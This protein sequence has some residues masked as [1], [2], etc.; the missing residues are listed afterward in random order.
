MRSVHRHTESLWQCRSQHLTLKALLYHY[1]VKG[2]PHQWLKSYITGR[3]QYTT[4]NHQ[5]SSLS[6]IK[7]GSLLRPLLFLLYIS[8]LNKAILLSKVHHFADDTNFLY[9]IYFF[10][11]LE[12]TVNSDLSNL[13]QW[14][15]VNK[16]SL[17][18]DKTEIVV[19]RSPT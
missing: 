18:V 11:N 6:N 10:K 8:D 5:N 1:S 13:V 17:N 12:K 3:E 9:V 7:Y 14:L 19:F 4:I 2:P 15:R 16:I